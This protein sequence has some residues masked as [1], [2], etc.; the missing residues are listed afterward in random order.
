MQKPEGFDEVQEMGGFTPVELGG[1]HMVIKGVKE[2]TTKTNK[3]MLVI[4]FDFAANDKQAGYF[5]DSFEKDIR[6]EKKWPNNGTNYL[7]TQD[8]QDPSKPSR[9][10]KTFISCIE[11]NNNMIV[12]WG[13]DDFC[14]QFKGKRIGGVFGIVEEEY[15]GKV[16]QRHKLRW[17]Y[18]DDKVDDAKIPNPKLLNNGASSVSDNNFMKIEEGADSEIPF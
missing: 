5:S 12:K 16:N 6:P 11:R 17:F 8:Y 13:T 14:D 15:N 7:M 18:D 9:Q 4:A 2:Q 10:F 3:P 1:H